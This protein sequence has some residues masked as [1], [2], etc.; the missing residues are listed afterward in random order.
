MFDD[1]GMN[2]PETK[3]SLLAQQQQLLSGLRLAQ[4]F[5]V[6]T[7]ELPLP[8]GLSRTVVERGVFHYDSARISESTVR[9]ASLMHREN[10]LLGLGPF[11]KRDILLRMGAG[12]PL[13]VLTERSP[14][15]HEIKA[16]VGVP[17]TLAVQRSILENSKTP[18]H[19]IRV[20][21]ADQLL[22]SRG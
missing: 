3:A 20:E 14:E 21:P 2:K 6:G 9:G 13:F 16:V 7:Q 18:G 1:T 4:M 10:E 15:G 5:P 8:K 17:S 22:Q 19:M 11:N 12:E